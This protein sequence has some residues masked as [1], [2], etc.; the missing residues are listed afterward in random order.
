MFTYPTQI[1]WLGFDPAF[2]YDLGSINILQNVYDNL[3]QFEGNKIVPVIAENVPSQ[4]SGTI[5]NNKIYIFKIRQ[6]I[7]F[8]NGDL[9]TP[10]DVK[11][12]IMRNL[13]IGYNNGPS[14]I[15]YKQFFDENSFD[16][17]FYKLNGIQYKDC[18]D[19]K[20]F[21]LEY[22]LSFYKFY[23]YINN[24]IKVDG[25]E[26]IF[27]LDKSNSSF[28]DIMQT[29]GTWAAIYN[30]AIMK[31]HDW[32]GTV[33]TALLLHTMQPED[34]YL[35]S[36]FQGSG[37]YRVF[38]ITENMCILKV[39]KN[40]YRVS[41]Y[42]KEAKIVVDKDKNSRYS[43]TV[44]GEYSII[45]P[46]NFSINMYK[47]H[48]GTYTIKN[49]L[50]I[51]NRGILLAWNVSPDQSVIFLDKWGDGFPQNAFI[52]INLRKA[53][54]SALPFYTTNLMYWNNTAIQ[55]PGAIPDGFPYFNIN[56]PMWQ[57]N[58]NIA[59][60]YFKKQW[61]G[62]VWK[63]GFKVSIY[64]F[65][66]SKVL[67]ILIQQYQDTLKMINLKFQLIPV[68]CSWKEYVEKLESN[69]LPIV[70]S[71][72]V[73][74]YFDQY[75]F[76][77]PYMSS[78]GLYGSELGQSYITWQKE[79]VDPILDKILVSNNS[80]IIQQYYNVL[81]QYNYYFQLGVYIQSQNYIIINNKYKYNT[82]SIYSG[83]Y[84]Y[85]VKSN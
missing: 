83:V 38:Y 46:Y 71:G 51:A 82:N 33:Y 73:A 85:Y 35:Y 43:K 74:D 80:N 57:S 70:Q 78:T 1:N 18:I 65:S 21:K 68:E 58:I 11:Y 77:Y 37:P 54:L 15:L 81:M 3:I 62:N 39:Q 10:Y 76:V 14:W 84:L 34:S 47:Q 75:D 7:H 59:T 50:S 52:D 13:L 56:I 66:G 31:V 24:H 60:D 42:I 25:N 44:S 48:K 9:I 12:S 2:A 41:S 67:G 26:I 63:K 28:L 36:H 32:D 64:Y 79:N 17:L 69:K 49:R 29:P 55:T 23:N 20:T 53:F 40:Y 8:H 27:I 30:S 72:W 6:N 45:E 4:Q 61:N 5:I 22:L 19:G 16:D